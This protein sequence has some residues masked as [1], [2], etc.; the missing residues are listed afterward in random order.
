MI[1]TISEALERGPISSKELQAM[2]G[3]SQTAVS[4][5]L[6]QLGDSIVTLKVG[7]TPRYIKTRNAFGG[8]DRIPLFAIDDHGGHCVAAYIRPLVSG[9]FHVEQVTGTSSLLLG[10][11]GT[12]LHE[13]LPY[14]LYDMC[15]QGFLGRQI[16]REIA[17]R[18]AD[19]PSDPRRWTTT[20][21][22]RYLLAN[23]EDAPG[24]FIFG[25]QALLRVR[26]KPLPVPDA[27]YPLMAQNVLDGIV[28]G[29]S[30]GG[31][32][33]K[34]TAFSAHG[35]CHV[36]VKF[37]PTGDNEVARR[38]K[39]ILITE[40]H[41][42][43]TIRTAGYPATETRLLDI[44]GRL[45]LELKRFDRV[46][47]YGRRS[48]L[49]LAAIDA[50]F[51]GA[52]NGWPRIARALVQQRRMSPSCL[53]M[54]E[55]LWCFGKR[56]HNT[57]MHL[58]NLSLALE[59]DRFRLLPNY[60]MCSMGFAPKSGGEVTPFRIPK[61]SFP[62]CDNAKDIRKATRQAADAFWTRVAD[63][64]RISDELRTFLEQA[65]MR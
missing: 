26:Q 3:L 41:G 2:T 14:F 35:G 23:G 59:G 40:H 34:F 37:S 12:G 38:W 24:N 60:D 20:H 36:I 16:A 65:D 9:G 50:E 22:G 33:P 46:G 5:Q 27:Q 30:A 43:E 6:R 1:R 51:V 42:L 49:S 19:F 29:S 44:E 48:M 61:I 58:G 52:G 28:P 10:E 17:A 56:I 8:T 13:D 45:F 57:D 11:G 54:V 32:Q 62:E 4:R 18:L 53:S 64:S 63:D 25:E 15:P 31:E 55:F 7:R 39:D 21:I 47:E